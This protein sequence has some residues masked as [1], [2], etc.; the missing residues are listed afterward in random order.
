MTVPFPPSQLGGNPFRSA[1][2]VLTPHEAHVVIVEYSLQQGRAQ[3]NLAGTII[4]VKAL[5]SKAIQGGVFSSNLGIQSRQRCENLIYTAEIEL[6]P[7]PLPAFSGASLFE[8]VEGSPS[9]ESEV[10]SPTERRLSGLSLALRTTPGSPR[11][12]S[13][14]ASSFGSSPDSRERSTSVGESSPSLLQAVEEKKE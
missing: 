4:K 7:K 10:V 1:L 12:D 3:G 5:L 11:F 13:R 9:R 14:A 6:L 2:P 8:R